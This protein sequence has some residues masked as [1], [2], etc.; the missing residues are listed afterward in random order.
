MCGG[1]WLL[2]WSRGSR[3]F[4]RLFGRLFTH[5]F[6]RHGFLAWVASA[7]T[8]TATTM[9]AITA[10]NTNTIANTAITTIA[11]TITTTTTSVSATT[12]AVTTAIIATTI[13]IDDSR[14][15]LHA[16]RASNQLWLATAQGSQHSR[17]AHHIGAIEA[18][19]HIVVGIVPHIV[20]PTPTP[21]TTTTTR[22]SP[23]ATTT[24]TP[25]TTPA[26]ATTTASTTGPAT[27]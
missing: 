14:T 13:I 15:G 20:T 22:A 24:A 9:A 21:S 17:G 8:I 27:H 26:A 12:I 11:T 6:S 1:E 5:W 4:I 25:T 23:L 10:A 16:A 3:W 18:P 7:S 2:V 19:P